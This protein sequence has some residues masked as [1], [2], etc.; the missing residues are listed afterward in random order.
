MPRPKKTR[1]ISQK[2]VVEHYKPAGIPLSEL[3]EVNL[4]VEELEAVRLADL[5][6]L[7]QEQAAQQMAVSRPT[8]QRV[9]S[10][11][12]TKIAQALSLGYSLKIKGGD[13]QMAPRRGRSGQG[14]G[15]R[16]KGRG[17]MGGPKAAG[18]G[19]NCVCTNPDCGYEVNHIAGE[20]CYQEKCPKCGSP[21]RRD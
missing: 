15:P 16:G 11:A 18:P 10:S 14:R 7:N 3:K 17:R 9:L 12:R 2:P 19:G 20:P 1:Y 6:N 5:E 4:N 13:F 21:M 8:F